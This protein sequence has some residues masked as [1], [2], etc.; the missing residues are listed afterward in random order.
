M[1]HKYAQ[2]KFPSFDPATDLPKALETTLGALLCNHSV[3]SW[4]ITA[5]GLNPTVVLRL[6]P[7]EHDYQHGSCV[8]TGVYR[9]KPSSQ[10]TR[11]RQRLAEYKQ[12]LVAR[13][14]TDPVSSYANLTPADDLGSKDGQGA[15]GGTVLSDIGSDTPLVDGTLDTDQ[16]MCVDRVERGENDSGGAA[17]VLVSESTDTCGA[18][19]AFR[20]ILLLAS[21]G[22]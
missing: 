6:K 18:D 16:D 11:D 7:F 1:S 4:K 12:R 20:P 13:K 5:E 14:A 3:T 8:Q 15:R 10:L 19:A 21:L 22:H 17:W 9:R 2:V